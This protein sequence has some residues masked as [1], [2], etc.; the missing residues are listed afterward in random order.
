VHLEYITVK[1][2]QCKTL[3]LVS[4]ELWPEI[5]SANYETWGVIRQLD[6]ELWVT[7]LNKK[8]SIHWQHSTPPISISVSV[9][10]TR[11]SVLWYTMEA[12]LWYSVY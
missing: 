4:P 9:H 6:R 5:N 3:N 2:L 11:A 10:F 8:A 12:N 1:L 7:R